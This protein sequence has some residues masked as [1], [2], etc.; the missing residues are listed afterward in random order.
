MERIEIDNLHSLQ[1]NPFSCLISILDYLRKCFKFVALLHFIQ[2]K[3][4][5]MN[6]LN[7]LIKERNK[8]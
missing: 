7:N 3:K 5:L 8:D 2:P 1:H 4:L 6:I